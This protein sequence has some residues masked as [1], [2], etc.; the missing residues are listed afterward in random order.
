[1]KMSNHSASCLRFWWFNFGAG[2]FV[3]YQTTSCWR[4][5]CFF[6]AN[7]CVYEIFTFHFTKC[8]CM[9][10][11]EICK[12]FSLFTVHQS[13]NKIALLHETK[14]ATSAKNFSRLKMHLFM[15]TERPSIARLE[16]ERNLLWWRLHSLRSN[17]FTVICQQAGKNAFQEPFSCKIYLSADNFFNCARWLIL[18]C[19]C[20]MNVYNYERHDQTLFAINGNMSCL[21]S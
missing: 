15:C 19:S 14:S 7:F 11:I 2:T 8:F 1:M 13:E 4:L 21:A 12:T 17:D 16:M 20:S 10:L 5:L 18:I 9:Q 3:E 6:C